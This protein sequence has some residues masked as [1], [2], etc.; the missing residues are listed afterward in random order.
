MTLFNSNLGRKLV[1][2]NN[3]KLLSE[4]VLSQWNWCKYHAVTYSFSSVPKKAGG[5]NFF[6]HIPSPALFP[7]S[8]AGSAQKV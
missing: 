6:T 4:A 1:F 2:L 7:L 8:F 5:D 3:Q